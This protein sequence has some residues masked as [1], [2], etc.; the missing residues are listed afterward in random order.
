MPTFITPVEV[1]PGTAGSWQ[2]VDVS[3][4]IPSGATGVILHCVNPTGDDTLDIGLRKNGSS[5]V[6]QS[7]INNDSH[8]WAMIGVDGSRIFEAYVGSTSLEI[9][10]TG[11]TTAEAVFLTNGVD[12]EPSQGSWLD[13]DC[14]TDA[15]DAIGLIFEVFTNVRSDGVGFRKNGSSDNRGTLYG[16]WKKF[17]AIIGCD[18]SQIVEVFV[19]NN[20]TAT[21]FLVGYITSGVTFNT[22]ATD[23][24]LGTTGSWLDLS[25]L[26]AGAT[27][28]I[29]E[30]YDDGQ[31][32][33]SYGLRKNGSAEDIY[34]RGRHHCWGI[35]EA[36]A[37]NKI[38]GKIL[39]T[40]IDFWLVGYVEGAVGGTIL[41]QITNAYMKVSA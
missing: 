15:P 31:V 12:K 20:T 11:Y 6:R 39:G 34:R 27:G 38:E 10:I 14:S 26:P 28:G 18:G 7:D 24:S 3:A 4:N 40:V 33:N 16:I 1:T 30:V 21:V 13:Q 29:I 2:D 17:W 9:W 25:T 41:P 37:D 8:Y 22:N 19:A 5:D 35:I 32:T 36:D 23:L